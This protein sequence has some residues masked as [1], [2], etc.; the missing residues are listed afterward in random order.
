LVAATTGDAATAIRNC[1]K[2]FGKADQ[3][4]RPLRVLAV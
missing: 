1:A 4:N 3:T 2:G